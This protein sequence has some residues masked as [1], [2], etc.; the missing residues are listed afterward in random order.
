M[1]LTVRGIV[2]GYGGDP[3][4][5]GVDLDV[6]AGELVSVL[7][8]SGSGKTTL[9]RVA[10]GLHR[11]DAGRVLVGG[12]DVTGVAPERRRVGLVPQEG[13]LFAHLD[14]RG[15]V[16]FGLAP[17]GLAR[18]RPDRAA[19]AVAR[20]RVAEL[21]DL[22]GLAGKADRMPHQLSGG[23]RRRV[24]LARAL[25]P[26]PEVVL[27]DEPFSALDAGLREQVR[28]DAVAA[29]RIAGS[30]AVLITHDRREALS[31]SDRVAVLHDGLLEQTAEPR[32]LY[33]TPATARVAGFVGDAAL[34]PGT[35]TGDRVRTALGSAP[36]RPGS[37]PAGEVLAVLRPE[38]LRLTPQTGPGDVGA[39]AAVEQVEFLGE[40][41]L[42]TARPEG[43][44]A[45]RVR[46][47][48]GEGW[49]TGDVCRVHTDGPV[50]VVP[51]R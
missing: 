31:V 27:L 30:T 24:A 5:H 40:A 47:A 38:Q 50:H 34:L 8:A 44:P 12:V 35:A 41:L 42:V 46:A 28:G 45:V 17:T 4:L 2:A 25:A 49:R 20:D 11:P 10:A 48:A 14:V 9:L 36:L 3:V 13:A 43:G 1:T 6:R 32:E 15:N 7:G 37:A 39:L 26:R 16:G 22:V 33:A 29:L 21:L 19:R 18:L 51:V 23:E